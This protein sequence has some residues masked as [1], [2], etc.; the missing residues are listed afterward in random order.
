MSKHSV[1]LNICGAE[2]VVASEDGESYIRSVA[3][4]VQDRMTALRKSNTH[5]SLTVTSIVAALSYCDDCRK[6]VTEAEH[7]RAQVKEY[8]ED[9]TRARKETEEAKAEIARLKKEIATLRARL[10]EDTDTP[11]EELREAP[12]Q[13]SRAGDFSRPGKDVTPEQEGLLAFFNDDENE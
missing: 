10:G 9:S 7:L 6:A 12:V 5:A 4:E 13:R 1:H 8:L 3:Q 2:C 11:A